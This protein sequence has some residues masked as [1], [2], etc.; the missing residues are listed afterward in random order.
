M[1]RQGEGERCHGHPGAIAELAD[2]QKIAH[3]QGFLQ[4]GGRYLVVL[5]EIDV[6]EVDG[7]QGKHNG[8]YPVE[9]GTECLVFKTTP[10]SPR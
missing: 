6:D 2:E 1:L 8:V 9:N 7:H 4:R 5:K 3:Q 10:K